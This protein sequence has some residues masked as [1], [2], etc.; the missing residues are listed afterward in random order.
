MVRVRFFLLKIK[1]SGSCFITTDRILTS[2][3]ALNASIEAARV[4][5]A[6]RGFAVV[7]DQ[8]G[9]LATDSANAVVSTKECILYFPIP[10]RQLHWRQPHLRNLPHET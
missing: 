9:K 6:G 7:A 2:L 4:G 10:R 3:L 5:D 1:I 8:I